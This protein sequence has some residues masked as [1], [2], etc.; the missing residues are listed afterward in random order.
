MTKL[1]DKPGGGMGG[2]VPPPVYASPTEVPDAPRDALQPEHV[3]PVEE[4]LSAEGT[5]FWRPGA[6]DIAKAMGWKWA[7]FLPAA[8][9]VI[10]IPVLMA[11]EWHAAAAMGA[12][13]IKIWLGC[14]GVA[15][16]V[17]LN[18]IRHSVKHR[19]DVFCI[20]CGYSIEDMGEKG[21]CPECGRP[22]VRAL[23][24]EYRKDPHFFR[25][26]YA[27]RRRHPVGFSLQAGEGQSEPDGT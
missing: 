13:A 12:G 15:I 7:F 18:A 11:I 17:V 21:T 2:L 14:L 10:A 20:H 23:S 8:V 25:H 9:G 3:L 22:F 16:T 5:P 19:S 24:D 26:R 27:V 4:M 1:P 6:T